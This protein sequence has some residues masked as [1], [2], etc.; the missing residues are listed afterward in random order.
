MMRVEEGL[1]RSKARPPLPY[2]E[3]DREKLRGGLIA[4]PAREEIPVPNNESLVVEYYARR[5]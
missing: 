1:I 2:I 5:M 4:L 3:V